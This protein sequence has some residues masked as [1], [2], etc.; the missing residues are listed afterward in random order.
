MQ[1]K[2]GK[3]KIFKKNLYLISIDRR[4]KALN[5]LN[6]DFKRPE[7]FYETYKQDRFDKLSGNNK[8]KLNLWQPV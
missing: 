8:I 6:K 7:N 1:K 5:P 4:I 3:T 2:V